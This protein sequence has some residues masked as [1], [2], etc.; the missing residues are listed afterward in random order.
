[1]TLEILETFPHKSETFPQRAPEVI[2]DI[3]DDNVS[4]MFYNLSPAAQAYEIKRAK[5]SNRIFYAVISAIAAATIGLPIYFGVNWANNQR[6]INQQQASWAFNAT[7]LGQTINGNFIAE[8]LDGEIRFIRAEGN[9]EIEEFLNFYPAI[10]SY[11]QFVLLPP[12]EAMDLLTWFVDDEPQNIEGLER[13]QQ[14]IG[15]K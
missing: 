2:N 12:E 7:L 11:E 13:L 4:S 15:N 5:R 14:L 6:E 8:G 10:D 1:M 9:L 3:N